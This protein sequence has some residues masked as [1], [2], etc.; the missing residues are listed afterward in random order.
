MEWYIHILKDIANILFYRVEALT[1]MSAKERYLSLL[2][3]DPAFI[4]KVYSKHLADYL[5]ITPVSFSR[6][7]NEINK[8]KDLL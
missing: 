1:T 5:G 6:I 8:E 4:D 3:L 2:K 7:L